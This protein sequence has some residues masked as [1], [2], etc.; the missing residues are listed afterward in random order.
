LMIVTSI[1]RLIVMK[2]GY[3]VKCM[4]WSIVCITTKESCAPYQLY[5]PTCGPSLA[6]M[7]YF[8]YT[9]VEVMIVLLLR[10]IGIHNKVCNPHWSLQIVSFPSPLK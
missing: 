8:L 4:G 2:V 1:Y 3:I 6:P 7:P 5:P 9:L 10:R